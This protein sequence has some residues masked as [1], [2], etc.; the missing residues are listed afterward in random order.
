MSAVNTVTRMR[1]VNVPVPPASKQ[2]PLVTC[3][4]WTVSAPLQTENH[5]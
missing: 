5:I 2:R 3:M 1:L 4:K